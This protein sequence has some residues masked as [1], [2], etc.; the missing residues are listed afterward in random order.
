[1]VSRRV[2]SELVESGPE[3]FESVLTRD[4]LRMLQRFYFI[5]VEFEIKLADPG[6]R[7]DCP[8]SGYLGVYKEALKVG[9]Q[10]PLHLFVVRLLNVFLLSSAQIAPNSWCF[11]IEFLSLCFLQGVE[12]TISLFRSCYLLK[13]IANDES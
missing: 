2:Q 12:P 7:V 1:M 5:L 4:D 13:A 11:V 9:L 8:P 3:G 6:E 10:F